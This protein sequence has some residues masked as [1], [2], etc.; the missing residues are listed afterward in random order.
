MMSLIIHEAAEEELWQEVA[1]YEREATGLGL[2]FSRTPSRCLSESKR[3][4]HDGN[5]HATAL[6][7]FYFG[8]SRTRSS[9][10]NCLN[11]YGLW[12]S[13]HKDGVP[14]T[15]NHG[16]KTALDRTE[17]KEYLGII[18]RT[19]EFFIQVE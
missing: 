15:G 18:S 19:P 7:R 8:A 14:S 2:D 5:A 3:L 13:H 1:Y 17:R 11:R 16:F 9:I 4:Q 12:Q 6:D 10:G